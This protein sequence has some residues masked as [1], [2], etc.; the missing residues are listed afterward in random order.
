MASPSQPWT[1][2][3]T[4]WYNRTTPHPSPHSLDFSR[5]SIILG[6]SFNAFGG[7]GFTGAIFTVPDTN[8]STN[9]SDTVVVT[10]I[11]GVLI[12]DPEDAERFKELARE[13]AEL[14]GIDKE[15]LARR[16]TRHYRIKHRVTC[17]PFTLLW[18]PRGSGGAS[19]RSGEGLAAARD[20][21]VGEEE[22]D[23][24]SVYGFAKDKQLLSEKGPGEESMLPESLWELLGLVQE[25]VQAAREEMRRNVLVEQQL[26]V[27]EADDS[28]RG[29]EKG[30]GM[31]DEIVLKKLLAIP[32]L[33][34][35]ANVKVGR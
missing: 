17:R 12:L 33:G 10:A 2:P 20:A 1:S 27:G 24:T 21:D 26:G 18:L 11:G 6:E 29:R 4:N 23:C 9:D 7:S 22:L 3:T 31:V 13:A 32:E 34:V 28:A 16:R 14:P 30:D 25:G 35:S 19:V 5:E 8:I 15:S